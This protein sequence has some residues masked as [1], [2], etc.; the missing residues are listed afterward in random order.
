MALVPLYEAL[1]H[2][3]LSALV[4]HADETQVSLLDPSAGMMRKAY[5]SA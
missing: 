1:R 5:V 3:I 2:F 4:L